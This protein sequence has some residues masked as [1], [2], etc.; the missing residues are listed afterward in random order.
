[1]CL[2]THSEN[3]DDAAL[4]FYQ[5]TTELDPK[6]AMA[7]R[8]LSIVYSGL[9]ESKQAA[10]C[11]TKAY[12]LRSRLTERERLSI[13]SNYYLIGTGELAKAEQVYELYVKTYPR[14]VGAHANLG[15]T[16]WSLGH[17]E[18]ALPEY[19]EAVRLDPD[20]VRG[21]TNVAGD[22]INLNRFEE[23]GEVLRKV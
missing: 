15:F 7:Y 12:E 3:G 20:N 2:M 18:R 23:A 10:R 11:A 13:E 21:Y 1:M 14:D 22:L 6:F 16:S 4:P 9:G 5:R 8:A 19:L 17:Y